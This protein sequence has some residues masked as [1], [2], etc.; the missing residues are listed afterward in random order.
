MLLTGTTLTVDLRDKAKADKVHEQLLALAKASLQPPADDEFGYYAPP[1]LKQIEFQGQT[2]HYVTGIEDMPLAP[3]WCVTE[4]HLIV[5]LYPQSI[6]AM[7]ARDEDYQS[8]A[9]T[10]EVAR[11]LGAKTAPL[12]AQYV[13]TKTVFEMLYPLAKI[14]ATGALNSA[15]EEGGIDIDVTILPRAETI[16]RHLRP[17]VMSITRSERGL[18]FATRQSLPGSS[19]GSSAPVAVALILPAIQAAREA[20]RRAQSM[21]N[22]KQI[23]LAIHNYESANRKLPSNTTTEDGKP[24]LSWRV[25]ILPYMGQ[26][27]LYDQFRMDEPWDSEHNRKLIEQMPTTYHSPGSTGPMDRTNYLGVGGEDGMFSTDGKEVSFAHV[28]DGLSQTAMVVEVDDRAAV[29]WTKPDDFDPADGMKPNH[30]LGGI[31]SSKVFLTAYGDGSVH[32]IHRDAAIDVLKA[33]FTKSGGEVFDWRD[34]EGPARG[35]EP[36]FIE[37]APREVVPDEFDAAP[38]EEDAV[39]E[40]FEA[41]P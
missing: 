35:D 10:E 34:L 8:L 19:M 32:A 26:Q 24:G 17:S 40:E 22:L 12:S 1:K 37:D 14:F 41:V 5:A 21:N 13:D 39:P 15:A 38:E 27:H 36:D 16:S 3:S 18:E 20:A 7:L 25:K 9:T 6:E 11:M 28:R 2:I 4:T 23:A 29:T 30:D 31:W 33:I